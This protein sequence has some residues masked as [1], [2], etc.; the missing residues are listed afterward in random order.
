MQSLIEWKRMKRNVQIIEKIYITSLLLFFFLLNGNT[1]AEWIF[2]KQ[3]SGDEWNKIKNNKPTT[4]YN[5]IYLFFA[6][7][8]IVCSFI[9]HIYYIY[10]WILFQWI[11]YIFTI[12]LLDWIHILKAIPWRIQKNT[13]TK[14]LWRYRFDLSIN[15]NFIVKHLLDV[16]SSNSDTMFSFYA[17]EYTTILKKLFISETYTVSVKHCMMIY[18]SNKALFLSNMKYMNNSYRKKLGILV[19]FAVAESRNLFH[20]AKKALSNR[21]EKEIY[22]QHLNWYTNN[23][24]ENNNNIKKCKTQ[25]QKGKNKKKWTRR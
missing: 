4:A 15:W 6:L 3:K 18:C 20:Q 22:F 7:L 23:K 13:H 5:F 8:L 19:N 14:R 10:C 17:N 25:S 1:S 12:K 9:C 2:A 11:C 16:F 21:I 24:F